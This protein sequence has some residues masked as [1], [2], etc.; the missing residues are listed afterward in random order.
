M[1]AARSLERMSL[2]R[3]ALEGTV[4]ISLGRWTSKVSNQQVWDGFVLILGFGVSGRLPVMSATVLILSVF[5]NHMD[6]KLPELRIAR[7]S[8]LIA[9]NNAFSCNLPQL[10]GMQP[11]FA[12]ALLGNYFKQPSDHFPSWVHES[13]NGPFF[14]VSNRHGNALVLKTLLGGA[15]LCVVWFYRIQSSGQTPN[16]LGS[17]PRP[18]LGTLQI[19]R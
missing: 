1:H 14:C 18:L 3:L 16:V 19:S 8:K 6:G 5:G 9:H 7:A 13:E 15:G 12:M 4:P 11:Q 2:S 10:G 17:G